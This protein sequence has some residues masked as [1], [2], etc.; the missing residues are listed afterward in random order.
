MIL[1]PHIGFQYDDIAFREFRSNRNSCPKLERSG[2]MIET[3]ICD[4]V[5]RTISQAF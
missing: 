5:E 2:Q 3:A 4:S 1:T